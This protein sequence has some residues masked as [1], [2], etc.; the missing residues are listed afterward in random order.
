M[1]T[2]SL[3]AS[4]SGFREKLVLCFSASRERLRS[5]LWLEVACDSYRLLLLLSPCV[6]KNRSGCGLTEISGCHL[7]R[8]QRVEL[9]KCCCLAVRQDLVPSIVVSSD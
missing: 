6:R 8:R 9:P 2:E 4:C 1:S 3:M 7:S 5:G